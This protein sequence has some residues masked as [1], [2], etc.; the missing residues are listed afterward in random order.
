MTNSQNK[1][2]SGPL[3]V[4]AIYKFVRLP[5]FEAM[6]EPI[7]KACRN[8]DC[9]GTLLLAKEGI[10]GTMAGSAE[11]IQSVIEFLQRDPRFD[12]LSIKFSTADKPPF[13]RMKVKIKN[14]I[15]T[16]GKPDIDPTRIV[17]TY[18]KPQDWNA[19]ISDPETLVVDTRNAYEVAIGSFSNALNPNTKS[20][21]DFPDWVQGLKN[22]IDQGTRPRPKKIAMFCT[23]GIRCEKSTAYIREQGFDKVFH[24]EGGILKYLEDVPESESLWSGQCFVFDQRVSVGHG[25][26]QGEY[27]QCHGCRHPITEQDKASPYYRL[28]V[29]CPNCYNKT[30]VEQKQRYASRQ[31]QMEL[32]ENRSQKHLGAVLKK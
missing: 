28:G 23:G 24:L 25:L 12:G 8:A 16:M 19:L 17:G 13:L 30:S 2:N 22:Q 18:V 10:N 20:F 14:E 21:R 9:L 26:E 31:K 32:A 15:V 5:D 27:D 29:S 4:A 7:L 11:N 3:T 6:R 1:T